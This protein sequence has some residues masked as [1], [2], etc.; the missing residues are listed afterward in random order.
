[1]RLP[2]GAHELELRNPKLGIVRRL[3]VVIRPGRVTR[4]QRDL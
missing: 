3:Q 1:V 2:S 4:V